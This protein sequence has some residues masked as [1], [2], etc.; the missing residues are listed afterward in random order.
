MAIT[1]GK[2]RI[3]TEQ[4]TKLEKQ[5]YSTQVDTTEVKSLSDSTASTESLSDSESYQDTLATATNTIKDHNASLEGIGVFENVICCKYPS[6][7]TRIPGYNMS[8]F[9]DLDLGF[10]VE[11]CGE[12]KRINP[13]DTAMQAVSFL[14]SNPGILAGDKQAILRALLSNDLTAKMNILGIAA[15][16]LTCILDKSGGSLSNFFSPY[17]LGSSLSTRN[18]L[19]Q[20]LRKDKCARVLA[21]KLGLFD[22]LASYNNSH[23]IN[24]ILDGDP[25]AAET[26]M[27]AVLSEGSDLS[28]RDFRLG[29]RQALLLGYSQSFSYSYS[30]SQ[31]YSKILILKS[32]R[33]QGLIT[34]KD[35][36]Y[37]NASS[38]DI[39]SN[40]DKDESKDKDFD[41][42]KS[43][44]DLLDPR[45]DKDTL[46][47]TNLSQAKDNETMKELATRKL[48]SSLN[49]ILVVTITYEEE[50]R[51][52]EPTTQ[53][54][55]TSYKSEQEAAKFIMNDQGLTSDKIPSIIASMREAI[56]DGSLVDNKYHIAYEFQDDESIELTGVYETHLKTEHHIAILSAF[57]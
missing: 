43:T 51:D 44:L 4:L 54:I 37:L 39:L 48:L 47:N 46:G 26:Y 31:T 24:M 34:A 36:I 33:S 23:F 5:D 15:P 55:T 42:I 27:F 14:A 12:S 6:L 57:E 10:N 17:G 22:A 45:W 41:T 49:N 16:L 13:I 2:D 21:S 19:N 1:T 56:I 30:S 29:S 18:R 9:R 38:K 40:L 25:T 35:K 8:L 53:I 50:V 32:A 52:E 7:S 11:I 28:Y 20:L 3:C